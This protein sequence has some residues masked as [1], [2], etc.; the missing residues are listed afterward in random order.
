MQTEYL[1]LSLSTTRCLCSSESPRR[2]QTQTGMHL[3]AGLA[4]S[5]KLIVS[6]CRE[7]LE[8]LHK[9]GFRTNM[10]PDDSGAY[11]LAWERGGGF[12]FGKFN[13]VIKEKYITDSYT[14]QTMA[15]ANSS[16]T[17]KSSLRAILRSHTSRRI[18]SLSRTVPSSLLMS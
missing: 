17:A 10:G 4:S 6:L 5:A 11:I 9:R 18:A 13:L 12:Y 2:S 3:F 15:A 16:S 7:L 14:C 8:G 1:L